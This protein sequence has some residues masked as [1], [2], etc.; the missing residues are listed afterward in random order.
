VISFIVATVI[1]IWLFSNQVFYEGLIAKATPIG[2]LTPL[3]GFVLAAG[4]Y[5]VLFRVLKPKLGGP[6]SDTPDLVVGVDPADVV[7]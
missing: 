7:A 3:I 4:L 2:D 6:L 1:S 5:W